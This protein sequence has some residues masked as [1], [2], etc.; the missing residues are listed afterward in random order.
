VDLSLAWDFDFWGRYRRFELG[1][2]QAHD[3]SARDLVLG[4]LRRP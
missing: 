1:L 4:G 2:A 3:R